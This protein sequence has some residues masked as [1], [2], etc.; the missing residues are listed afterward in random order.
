MQI[1]SPINNP[2]QGILVHCCYWWGFKYNV[3]KKPPKKEFCNT[4][5]FQ[6]Y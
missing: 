6:S 1:G 4:E 2:V 5:T 3:I